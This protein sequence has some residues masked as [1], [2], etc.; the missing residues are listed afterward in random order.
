MIERFNFFPDKSSRAAVADAA[1]S[2][3]PEWARRFIAAFRQR[4]ASG[5]STRGMRPA[6]F[7]GV[8]VQMAEARS[9]CVVEFDDIRAEDGSSLVKVP[10]HVRALVSSWQISPSRFTQRQRH[11]GKTADMIARR[12]QLLMNAIL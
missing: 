1:L 7:G 2:T 8:N 12:R 3:A 10:P 6:D 11:E 4:K 5:Q 9:H